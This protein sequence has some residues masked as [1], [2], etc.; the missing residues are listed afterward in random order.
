MSDYGSSC[1]AGGHLSR[2][3]GYDGP[4]SGL[5]NREPPFEGR[6]ATRDP[7]VR[8]LDFPRMLKDGEG[9]VRVPFELAVAQAQ[10]GIGEGFKELSPQKRERY[11]ADSRLA[12]VSLFPSGAVHMVTLENGILHL[13]DNAPVAEALMRLVE[14]NGFVHGWP[15]ISSIVEGGGVRSVSE[16]I[17]LIYT[18][19]CIDGYIDECVADAWEGLAP[20]LRSG[21]IRC[22]DVV[23]TQFAT[24]TMGNR[25]RAGECLAMRR[26]V[27]DEGW[28]PERA[29]R[30]IDFLMSLHH[31]AGDTGYDLCEELAAFGP[32]VEAVIKDAPWIWHDVT[33]PAEMLGAHA[34]EKDED[35]SEDYADQVHPIF[36]ALR[37]GDAQGAVETFDRLYVAVFGRQPPQE[38][39]HLVE[40]DTCSCRFA[41]EVVENCANQKE[42]HADGSGLKNVLDGYRAW[43]LEERRAAWTR[44]VGDLAI[45]P[46]GKYPQEFVV[47]PAGLTLEDRVA[48]LFREAFEPYREAERSRANS[49]AI[50]R[51][52][53]TL[54]QACAEAFFGIGSV[55]RVPAD[56]A[57]DDGG[58]PRFTVRIG[59]WAME[60]DD[61]RLGLEGPDWP[62]DEWEG[63]A[64]ANR[65]LDANDWDEIRAL[66]AD[67]WVTGAV[68]SAAYTVNRLVQTC[69]TGIDEHYRRRGEEWVEAGSEGDGP[70]TATFLAL[71]HCVIKRCG[72]MR[73]IGSSQH[74]FGQLTLV[75]DEL[76]RGLHQ[77]GLPMSN[78]YESRYGGISFNAFDHVLEHLLG[79]DEETWHRLRD[80]ADDGHRPD[81]P[82]LS[83]EE[84]RLASKLDFYCMLD[85]YGEHSD[86]RLPLDVAIQEAQHSIDEALACL[87]EEQQARYRAAQ[88]YDIKPL[89]PSGEVCVIELEDG[90]LRSLGF[91][92]L[93]ERYGEFFREE[94][95]P[96]KED[97]W[98]VSALVARRYAIPDGKVGFG[99]RDK[100][101]RAAEWDELERLINDGRI[102]YSDVV[103]TM[104]DND[105]RG[106]GTRA[107]DCLTFHNLVNELGWT[108]ALAA[109]AMPFV[110]SLHHA[111]G[112]E[113]ADMSGDLLAFNKTCFGQLMAMGD[114]DCDHIMRWLVYDVAIPP[115]YDSD[116]AW[117]EEDLRWHEWS[118]KAVGAV[119]H[120]AL[121]ALRAGDA[122]T[123]MGLLR[124]LYC[125]RF[126]KEP[127]F[128]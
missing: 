127:G 100:E 83:E 40:R 63:F 4:G 124:P 53:H 25:D 14:G 17:A 48:Q 121:A 76:D 128:H 7:L 66:L 120:D 59:S 61:R 77:L 18:A 19:Q 2:I 74:A 126:G 15:R 109:Y 34:A 101:L 46:P 71:L 37:A 6:V 113:P 88:S 86:V 92:E 84:E 26:L 1:L 8:K 106:P 21:A 119:A 13:W 55:E 16:L 36:D 56:V 96:D 103:A 105:W 27:G 82:P 104:L 99:A 79:P 114:H 65:V 49:A 62:A 3:L 33:G 43:L 11:L 122:E 110:S 57:A 116:G 111:A 64:Q 112:D 94:T 22:A 93:Y 125:E 31:L 29:R 35:D 89:L 70:R 28:E 85:R 52:V 117:D 60:L 68:N 38:V 108:H 87:T 80:E 41:R 44:I 20:L 45:L 42:M 95:R 67:A 30:L 12:L 23:A 24:Y 123:V 32:T 97:V 102:T 39:A 98:S 107:A 73:G 47:A 81:W 58:R 78:R 90:I 9:R 69:E 50:G 51:A 5:L 72:G 91:K 54:T 10:R 118:R 75:F 115:D